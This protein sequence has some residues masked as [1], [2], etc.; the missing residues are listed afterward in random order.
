M[1]AATA[2]VATIVSGLLYARAF[3]TT[4]DHVLAW[5]AL[6]PWLVVLRAGST[7]RA[8]LLAWVWALASAY[9]V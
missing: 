2:L 6:V 4:N 7:R 5:V 8:V 1:R 3:P 9:V